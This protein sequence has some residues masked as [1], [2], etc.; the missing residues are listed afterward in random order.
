MLERALLLPF[1]DGRVWVGFQGLDGLQILASRPHPCGGDPDPCAPCKQVLPKRFGCATHG[2]QC[3]L[4]ATCTRSEIAWMGH[5][6]SEQLLAELAGWQMKRRDSTAECKRCVQR[7]SG[8]GRTGI[9]RMLP[10]LVR[11]GTGS[12]IFGHLQPGTRTRGK[13]GHE[14]HA[15][16]VNWM[17]GGPVQVLTARVQSTRST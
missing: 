15:F 10:W 8:Q 11:C 7:G 12:S 3:Y 17:L 4:A 9:R 16:H 14:E 2:T 13:A 1:P 6:Q 5:G